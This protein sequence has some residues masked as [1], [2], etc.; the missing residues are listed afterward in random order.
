MVLWLLLSAMGAAFVAAARN[1]GGGNGLKTMTARRADG[2]A[3]PGKGGGTKAAGRP[4]ASG[5]RVF[6]KRPTW[7]KWYKV[8]AVS[9]SP[10]QVVPTSFSTT[11]GNEEQGVLIKNPG[12]AFAWR[13]Y[14]TWGKTKTK[15]AD[16][17]YKSGFKGLNPL[18]GPWSGA[19]TLLG[20]RKDIEGVV[21]K[22]ISQDWVGMG[23]D[24]AKTALK[25]IKGTMDRYKA[26]GKMVRDINYAYQANIAS[27]PQNQQYRDAESVGGAG[28]NLEVG[29]SI[30][31]PFPSEFW[32]GGDG[33]PNTG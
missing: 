24:A 15:A 10:I 23:T 28:L 13:S 6:T 2:K 21:N 8:T 11:R 19:R 5:G 4:G 22:G 18:V 25:G 9:L 26:A 29:D 33:K 17:K 27:A 14:M 30:Y 32:Q 1:G 31:I 12:Q 3:A 16:A 20:L 7:G